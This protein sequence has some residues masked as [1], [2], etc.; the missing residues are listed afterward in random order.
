VPYTVLVD[1]NFHYMNE[2]ERYELGE[3]E[4]WDTALAAA[5]QIVDRFLASAVRPGMTAEELYDHYRGFG[6]DP[7]I[8]PATATD[9]RRAFSAWSYAKDRCMQLCPAVNEGS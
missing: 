4:T 5:Q 3:F 6:E 2:A 9:E 1:D 8:V 7:F